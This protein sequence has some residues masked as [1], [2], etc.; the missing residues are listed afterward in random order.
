LDNALLVATP[1]VA[2]VLGALWERSRH[3]GML[4]FIGVIR[5]AGEL[6]RSDFARWPGTLEEL[7]RGAVQGAFASAVFLPALA[8]I[9]FVGQ[10][11][12][13]ARQGSLVD[14][15]DRLWPWRACAL[16]V[17]IAVLVMSPSRQGPADAVVLASLLAGAA[18]FVSV[19]AAVARWRMA[20]RHARGA[21]SATETPA[22][23]AAR[24]VDAGV[25]EG[26]VVIEPGAGHYRGWA[27]GGVAYRGDFAKASE[28]LRADAW[29][30]AQCLAVVAL[31]LGLELSSW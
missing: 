15:A 12:G 31:A 26:A 20:V 11:I 24:T 3:R 6:V 21:S 30:A 8:A 1:I 2:A 4:A 10:R 25:G 13:R 22:A 29:S 14:G 5:A 9:A 28:L 23:F 18:S 16:A 7:C 27:K 19:A 17:A